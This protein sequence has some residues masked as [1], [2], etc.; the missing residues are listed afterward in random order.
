LVRALRASAAFCS[1]GSSTVSEIIVFPCATPRMRAA[2]AG[3]SCTG[4]QPR[5]RCAGTRF[6][7]SRAAQRRYAARYGERQMVLGAA[8]A[9]RR[10]HEPGVY[11]CREKAPEKARVQ[12]IR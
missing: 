9:H 2:S 5:Q 8:N 1:S 3:S 12:S 11:F 10:P 4:P 7:H 6:R